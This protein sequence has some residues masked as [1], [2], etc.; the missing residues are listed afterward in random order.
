M[1]KSTAFSSVF[2]A[3][4]QTRNNNK[5]ME[6]QTARFFLWICA[7]IAE[8]MK[9]QKKNRKKLSR[10][11]GAQQKSRAKY[12]DVKKEAEFY[13]MRVGGW[14]GWVVF[15]KDLFCGCKI[16]DFFVLWILKCH[17]KFMSWKFTW[18]LCQH[19]ICVIVWNWRKFF[20]NWNY[21]NRGPPSICSC[22]RRSEWCVR[23]D[24]WTKT[25]GAIRKLR[26]AKND[27]FD[28]HSPPPPGHKIYKE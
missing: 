3:Q 26:H 19:S 5:E 17:K 20:V 12:W 4:T 15:W 27:F 16:I 14:W 28:T 23:S 1:W 11:F 21:A 22:N 25:K 7:R 18:N 9:I 24:K 2:Y 13:L 10:Q 8:E 6:L